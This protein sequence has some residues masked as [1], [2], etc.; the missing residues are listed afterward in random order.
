MLAVRAMLAMDGND[1]NGNA[2]DAMMAV[3]AMMAMMTKLATLAK[4]AG[5]AGHI[6]QRERQGEGQGTKSMQGWSLH[7]VTG[8]WL[9]MALNSHGKPRAIPDSMTALACA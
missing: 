3:M 1:G 5:R 6:G 7:V 4:L 8:P 9:A 2:G